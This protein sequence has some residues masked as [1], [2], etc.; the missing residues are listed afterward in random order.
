MQKFSGLIL[1]GVLALLAA[2]CVWVS[3]DAFMEPHPE[4]EPLQLVPEG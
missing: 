3:M 2:V 1:A 4:V